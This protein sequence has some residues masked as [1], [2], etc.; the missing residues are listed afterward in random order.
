MNKN[1]IIGCILGTAVGDSMGLPYE[2]MNAGRVRKF[3]K[4]PLSQRLLHS[5]GMISDDSE[6]TCFVAKAL[7]QADGDV[8]VFEKKLAWDLRWWFAGLPAGVG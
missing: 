8:S 2:G 6:H 3:L 1:V 4:K 7:M 5:Y